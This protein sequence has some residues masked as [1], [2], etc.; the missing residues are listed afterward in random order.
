MAKKRNA[1]YTAKNILSFLKQLSLQK[2]IPLFST[3]HHYNYEF[4]GVVVREY[5]I[6]I[7]VSFDII[8][9]RNKICQNL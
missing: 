1:K 6:E 4:F 5:V 2:S 3:S 9:V 8:V 7:K